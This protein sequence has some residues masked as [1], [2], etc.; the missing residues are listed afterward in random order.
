M[1]HLI[2]VISLLS[3]ISSSYY[4]EDITFRWAMFWIPSTQTKVTI[5]SIWKIKYKCFGKLSSEVC[6]LKVNLHN[7]SKHWLW[8]ITSLG[9]AAPHWPSSVLKVAAFF[10]YHPQ[11]TC[12][13][14]VFVGTSPVFPQDVSVALYHCHSPPRICVKEAFESLLAAPDAQLNIGTV[15]WKI[16][17]SLRLRETFHARLS[18]LFRHN[19]RTFFWESF[20]AE[21]V[22]R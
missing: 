7:V 11:K 17:L 21:M 16:Q 1:C 22:S 2:H 15:G 20:Q 19:R 6:V 9:C 8:T 3:S 18:K 10:I 12:S 4:G 14:N 5:L 13:G